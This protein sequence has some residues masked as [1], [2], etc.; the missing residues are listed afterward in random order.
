MTDVN[1]IRYED[2][3]NKVRA[4]THHTFLHA[5]EVRPYASRFHFDLAR[6]VLH[7]AGLSRNA[8]VAILEAVLLLHRGLAIHEDVDDPIELKRQL[9]VLAGDYCSSQY[10]WIVAR[11][12]DERLVQALS[13]S[14]VRINEA[15]MAVHRHS[16]ELSAK[17]YIQ[18]Q[19]TIHG[20]LLFTLAQRYLNGDEL[21]LT[22]LRSA[23]F[24]YIVHHEMTHPNP[25]RPFSL[26]QALEWLSEAK[27]RLFQSPIATVIGPVRGFMLDTWDSLQTLLE[28]QSLAEGKR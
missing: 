6:T 4:Y 26:A 18:L 15:K 20:D 25:T 1:L 10:Y 13:D 23:V 17:Q 19:E 7:Q 8:S 24:G 3:D 11:V 5:A 22:A 2:V 16:A 14:V 9:R 27:D 28:Q 12:G 21:W